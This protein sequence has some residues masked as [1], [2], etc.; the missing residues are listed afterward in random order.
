MARLTLVAKTAI[1]VLVL[2][3]VGAVLL[4]KR[5]P[6]RL[7]LSIDPAHPEQGVAMHKR[8]LRRNQ[9]LL[10]EGGASTCRNTRGGRYYLTDER[11]I[12]C[13]RELAEHGG[14]RHGCCPDS[15]PP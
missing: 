2:T 9:R 14:D 6:N 15:V 3:V 4:T 13:K 12:I 1:G 11:G 5:D 10:N 7:S 8:L